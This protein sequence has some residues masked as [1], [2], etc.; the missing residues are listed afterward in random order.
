[1]PVPS[2][3]LEEKQQWKDTDLVLSECAAMTKGLTAEDFAG[4][5]P[6][7]AKTTGQKL[8]VG[9]GITGV[10]GQAEAGFPAVKNIGL[11]TLEAALAAG[12]TWNEAGCAALLSMLAQTVDTNMIHR[13]GMET[14]R[15]IMDLLQGIL[16]EEPYPSRETLENLDRLFVQKN[17]SPGGTAD[18]L[19]L[20]YFLHF[21]KE[22]GH[23]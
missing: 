5:T 8:Y 10:R 13:G 9:Y 20:V 4:L 23:E 14:T 1:M 21:L 6:E 11:P 16:A 7:T 19:A 15:E 18:L 17:L 3:I 2:D 22:E 12:K